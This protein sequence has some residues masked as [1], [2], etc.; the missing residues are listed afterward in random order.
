MKD[1]LIWPWMESDR[2]IS[3]RR[4]LAMIFVAFAG[5]LFWEGFRFADHGWFVFL[6]G[7]ICVAAALLLLFFTTWADIT[8]LVKSALG[9]RSPGDG[10]PRN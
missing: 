9:N 8:E 5:W 1:H 6:P 2:S 7:I 10:D 3:A 4:C